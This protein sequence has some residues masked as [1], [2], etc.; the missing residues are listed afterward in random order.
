MRQGTT[1]ASKI[2]AVGERLDWASYA[3]FA[4]S[5]MTNV[6]WVSMTILQQPVSSCFKL[7]IG[8]DRVLGYLSQP[9]TP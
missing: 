3:T 7:C 8:I 5:E 6:E 9:A 1:P 4:T 2:F